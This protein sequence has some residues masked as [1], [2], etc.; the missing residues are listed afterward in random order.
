MTDGSYSPHKQELPSRRRIISLPRQENSSPAVAATSSRSVTRTPPVGGPSRVKS[1]GVARGSQAK[2]QTKPTPPAPALDAVRERRRLA[3]RT[4]RKWLREAFPLLFHDNPIPPL[5]VG[6]TDDIAAH[7]S[8]PVDISRTAVATAVKYHVQSREY[9]AAL[10]SE[11]AHR[12]DLDARPVGFVTATD[13]ANARER[14][15]KFYGLALP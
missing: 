10:A 2:A 6:I 3:R 5:A 8:K 13:R 15:Q 1:P 14:Y 4:A 9:L 11:G 12:Y 7:P